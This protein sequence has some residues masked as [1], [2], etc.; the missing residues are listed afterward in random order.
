MF[1][2]LPA[3]FALVLTA[4][5]SVSATAQTDYRVDVEQFYQQLLEN[6]PAP[7]A[8]TSQAAWE[9]HYTDLMAAAQSMSEDEFLVRMSGFAALVG[10]GH[11][12]LLPF[13]APPESFANRLPVRFDVFEEGVFITHTTAPLAH[14]AG[15]KIT[16]INGP[17]IE[18]I[19]AEFSAVIGSDNPQWAKRW[20]PTLLTYPNYLEGLQLG[21]GDRN[22]PQQFE[23][24][25]EGQ[26]IFADITASAARAPLAE[27]RSSVSELIDPALIY[28]F[29]QLPDTD[30]VYAVYREVADSED[31]TV[32]QFAARLFAYIE[33]NQIDRLIFDI[34]ENG[35]GNNYLNQ[36]F[37]HGMIASRVNRPGG[38]YILTGRMTFSAA[39]NIATRTERHTQ[40]LFVGEDT[41]GAPN[42]YGDPTFGALPVSGLPY[43]MSTLFWQDSQPDDQRNTLTPD[44]QVAVRWSDW[45]EGRDA[46][47]ETAIRH[48][49]PDGTEVV[50]PPARWARASQVNPRGAPE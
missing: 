48:Q 41:S 19:V 5:L 16:A 24:E 22:A 29:T 33:D 9:T 43:I 3:L 50:S 18:T 30:T 34:R 37:L 21:A 44:I 47:L 13:Y 10:D 45:V 1:R 15:A 6:H 46:A 31:E 7:Y 49:V 12:N 4:S 27:A 40:A 11:T 28:G 38:L 39:M 26:T 2:A 8:R 25:L 14:L 17:A 35:G 20:L 36:P 32:A 23:L 42:H